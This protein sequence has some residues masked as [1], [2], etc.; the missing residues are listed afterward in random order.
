MTRDKGR[1]PLYGSRQRL[2]GM[3]TGLMAIVMLAL[4]VA[5]AAAEYDEIFLWRVPGAQNSM[6]LMGSVHLLPPEAYPLPLPLERAYRDS[7]LV[8]MEADINRVQ[9]SDA[10][11]AL[12][13]AGTYPP[14]ERL[15]E[16]ISWEL[17]RRVA[18]AAQWLTIP[19][20]VLDGYRPWYTGLTMEVTAYLKQGYRPELGIDSHFAK[21]AARDNKNTIFLETL[22]EQAEF[23]TSMSPDMSR[24]YLALTLT[25]LETM[26]EEPNALLEIWLEGDEGELEDFVDEIQSEYPAIYRQLILTRNRKW[27]DQTREL[28]DSSDDVLMVVG[29]MHLFGEHGLLEL[30]EQLG[31]EP[32]RVELD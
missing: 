20:T 25:N 12:I 6:Y 13:E 2:A 24:D 30:L 11:S 14:G 28:L 5:S 9:D 17:Y 21:L 10:Q 22:D 1:S 26:R 29:A 31:Y 19:M 3:L 32:E 16:N 23:F 8:V 7:Q 18:R 15:R 27:I 4:P